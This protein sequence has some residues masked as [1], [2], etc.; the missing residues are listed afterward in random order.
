MTPPP[1]LT[2]KRALAR[3]ALWF[4]QLWPAAWPPL[5]VLGAFAVLALLDVP[6]HLPPALRLAIPVVVVLVA[7]GLFARRLRRIVQPGA[8]RVDRRLERDSGLRHRPLAALQ[9]QP[10]MVSPEGANLWA[11][12]QQRLRAQIGRLRVSLPRP[13]LAAEDRTGL[14]YLVGIALAATFVIAGP[15]ALGRLAAAAWPG[16]PAGPA[17]PGTVVQAWITPPAY[18]GLPPVFLQPGATP[19]PVPT[20]AHLTVS[21]TGVPSQVQV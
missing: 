3:A 16:L 7:A 14:R 1:G 8:D 9:D 6:A 17:A 18:T 15:D 20:G 11:L 21:V 5:G 4:E 19:A 13:G 12:H 2:R 10:A